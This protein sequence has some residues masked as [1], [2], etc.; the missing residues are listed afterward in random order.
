MTIKYLSINNSSININ[1]IPKLNTENTFTKNMKITNTNK[2]QNKAQSIL[3]IRDEYYSYTSPDRVSDSLNTISFQDCN[4][5]WYG[6]CEQ[7]TNV[8]N[9][10]TEVDLGI[11]NIDANQW[12]YL[13]I[14]LNNGEIYTRCPTPVSNSNSTQIATTAWVRALLASKGIS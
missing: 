10:F 14:G 2:Y 6:V 7:R 11:Q 13:G 3:Y 8:N 1:N 5:N 9:D 4:N 12:N